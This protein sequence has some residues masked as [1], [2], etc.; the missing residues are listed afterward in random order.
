MERNILY[1]FF[2]CA[3]SYTLKDA[4]LGIGL[5]R[6]PESHLALLS[7]HLGIISLGVCL[8]QETPAINIIWI[9]LVICPFSPHWWLW[10]G[11]PGISYSHAHKP[12]VPLFT[13]N[14]FVT[15]IK[16]CLFQRCPYLPR[17]LISNHNGRAEL[18][19]STALQTCNLENLRDSLF[20]MTAMSDS[21]I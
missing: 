20:L 9:K 18:F 14:A 17:T 1:F 5:K 19:W 15:G 12:S 7:S 4:H 6:L 10:A 13:L 8:L 16:A 11:F 3:W 21:N 2:F